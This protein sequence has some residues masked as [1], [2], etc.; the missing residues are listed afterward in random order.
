VLNGEISSFEEGIYELV[1]KNTYTNSLQL[2]IVESSIKYNSKYF[3]DF[4][5]LEYVNKNDRMIQLKLIL[6]KEKTFL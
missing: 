1:F 3:N 6:K 4:K 5:R 2:S